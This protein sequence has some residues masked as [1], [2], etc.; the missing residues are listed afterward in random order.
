MSLTS[1]R[2]APPRV[3][4]FRDNRLNRLGAQV[5]FLLCQT[6]KSNGYPL[7]RVVTSTSRGSWTAWL[8]Q[9]NFLELTDPHQ[10]RNHA[11]YER[12]LERAYFTSRISQKHGPFYDHLRVGRRSDYLPI[13]ATGCRGGRS[14]SQRPP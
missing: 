6:A 8:R 7:I 10:R 13:N 2:A 1:Y 14:S 4:M 12:F 11:T 3:P 5:Y 9:A